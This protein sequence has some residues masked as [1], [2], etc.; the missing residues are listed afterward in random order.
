MGWL[1]GESR[2]PLHCGAQRPSGDYPTSTLATKATIG[3]ALGST[4]W[5]ADPNS[6]LG[7]K[8]YLWTATQVN[9]PP[10]HHARR[11]PAFS[12]HIQPSQFIP[13]LITLRRESRSPIRIQLS[14]VNSTRHPLKRSRIPNR[15]SSL[16]HHPS[17]H[18]R[19]R[20][21]SGDYPIS[22]HSGRKSYLWTAA[23]QINSSSPVHYTPKRA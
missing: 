11:A 5:I 14:Q 13:L 17:L 10:S 2:T 19:A 21:P 7:K 16:S 8:P 18:C 15:K 9:Q 23:T 6:H 12:I 4:T 22:S 3:W 1:V 20:R